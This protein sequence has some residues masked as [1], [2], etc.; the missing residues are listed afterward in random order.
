MLYHRV[1]LIIIRSEP[2][3]ATSRVIFRSKNLN[4]DINNVKLLHSLFLC[5]TKLSFPSPSRRNLACLTL[6]LLQVPWKHL[7]NKNAHQNLNFLQQRQRQWNFYWIPE[8]SFSIQSWA[9]EEASD[10]PEHDKAQSLWGFFLPFPAISR[11]NPQSQFPAWCLS[12]L[13]RSLQTKPHQGPST[14]PGT[15]ALLKSLNNQE[16]LQD[17]GMFIL[18]KYGYTRWIQG[19]VLPPPRMTLKHLGKK[20]FI[21]GQKCQICHTFHCYFLPWVFQKTQILSLQLFK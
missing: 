19:Q 14:Y 12:C 17:L 15:A 21:T 10:S 4:L 5:F 11:Q 3:Q 20:C 13:F 8:P 2:F 6:N 9:G 7:N 16:L 1:L 18:D